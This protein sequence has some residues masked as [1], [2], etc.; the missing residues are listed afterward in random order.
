MLGWDLRLVPRGGAIHLLLRETR[1]HQ[2]S[3]APTLH[4][5]GPSSGS[6]IVVCFPC[7]M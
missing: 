3:P 4:G 7:L 5:P 1:S 6:G 2:Q